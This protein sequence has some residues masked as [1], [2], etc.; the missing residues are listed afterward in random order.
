M[1]DTPP[2]APTPPATPAPPSSPTPPSGTPTSVSPPELA[3]MVAPEYR[4]PDHESVPQYL[5]G[6]T[7][8]DAA[9][10]LQAMVDS[11]ARGAAAPAAI[12]AP[13]PAAT[14]D[15]YVTGAHLRQAQQQALAQGKPVPPTVAEQPGTLR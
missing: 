5:R 8:S 3:T 2:A 10:L 12:P 15:D 11:A 7:A 14:D 9:Q 1:P 6:K 4:Y 13:L